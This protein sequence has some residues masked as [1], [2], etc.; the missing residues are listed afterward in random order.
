MG[1]SVTAV[2]G[3][4][5]NIADLDRLYAQDFRR[6]WRHVV[7]LNVAGSGPIGSKETMQR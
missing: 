4:V 1:R 6:R 3:N 5:S 7:S 2:Q